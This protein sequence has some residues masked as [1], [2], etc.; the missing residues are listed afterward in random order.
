M[1]GKKV[2]AF[3][4]GAGSGR[5]ILGLWDPEKGLHTVRELYR[6]PHAYVRIGE[7][8]YWDYV[9]IYRG[10]LESLRACAKEGIVP[11]S[12]GID[13]WAQ[14]F[15]YIGKDGEV[16]GL[17]RSYRDP[18]LSEHGRTFEEMTGVADDWLENVN[19][20]HFGPILTF[21]QL[22]YDRVY[23]KDTFD[24]ADRFVWMAYLF[25]Y[26]LTGEAACDLSMVSLGGFCD[27]NTLA[28]SPFAGTLAGVADKFPKMYKAGEIIGYTG[29]AV[30][31][32][33]GLDHIPVVCVEAH[34]TNSAVSAI[35]DAGEY[36]WASNG[37]FAMYGAVTKEAFRSRE[38]NASPLG[39]TRMADGRVVMQAGNGSGMYHIEQC[40][41]YWAANGTD[42]PYDMLTAYAMTHKTDRTFSF[43]DIDD[44]AVDMPSEIANAVEKAGYTRPEGPEE[45]Y[46]AFCNALSQRIC[47]VLSELEKIV[48][49][50]FSK[51]YIISGGAKA[52]GV[53][54]R[55]AALTGKETYAGPY[56][57]SA[58]GNLK[59]QLIPYAGYGV[60][61]TS[62]EGSVREVREWTLN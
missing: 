6:F 51:L 17:P 55:L 42:V 11:D 32:A 46:E 4:I 59:A 56:E 44:T 47:G 9:C 24:R 21:R 10:I 50:T 45:I 16:M 52:E 49:R 18:V 57:A 22:C 37:S 12:I 35:P 62:P 40:R 1:T 54:V 7:R 26:L 14:D 34:D 58:I 43:E 39:N 15:A 28:Y 31:A 60:A 8:F 27:A 25:V 41:K 23:K 33:S 30:K 38:L 61:C 53:N 3:D 48:G 29:E 5:A 36:L 19:G 13:T 2:L 20:C